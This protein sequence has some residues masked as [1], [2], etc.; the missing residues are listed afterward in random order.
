[1]PVR[2]VQ[3]LLAPPKLW[4]Q[5][6]LRTFW[7]LSYNMF[8]HFQVSTQWLVILGF[9]HPSLWNDSPDLDEMNWSWS[10]YAW[11]PGGGARGSWMMVVMLRGFPLTHVRLPPENGP[12]PKRKRSSSNRGHVS[13]RARTLN[14]L[15]GECN[16]ESQ[17]F[18]SHDHCWRGCPSTFKK[19]CSRK[20]LQYY[21]DLLHSIYST[22]LL[23][24]ELE[25]TRFPALGPNSEDAMIGRISLKEN[26]SNR[27]RLERELK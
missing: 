13:F 20:N 5:Q 4:W 1:M 15:L 21:W 11:Y 10:P 24:L 9:Q 22:A 23:L 27:V 8:I 7:I 25:A 3:Q 17:Q 19:L 6:N 12:E 14:F 16:Y 2:W 18:C 26:K